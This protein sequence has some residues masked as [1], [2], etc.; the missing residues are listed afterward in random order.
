[1]SRNCAK[2]EVATKKE[3]S[4]LQSVTAKS[5]N[6]RVPKGSYVSQ[7]QRQ[8]AKY[9]WQHQGELCQLKTSPPSE[10][11]RTPMTLD[12]AARIQRATANENHGMVPK[13]SFASRAQRA[14]ERNCF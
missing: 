2:A 6:G 3:I 12:A 13:K 10:Y 5:N 8:T 9:V 4:R 1:M 7:L 14:A 11:K